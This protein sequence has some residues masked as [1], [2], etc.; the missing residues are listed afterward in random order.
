M[1]K[2]KSHWSL[3]K[4]SEIL[5]FFIAGDVMTGR[6]I[7]QLFAIQN[8]EDFGKHDSVPASQYQAWSTE[9]YGEV[10]KPV[11][12][13]YIWGSSLDVLK[14]AEPDFRLINLETAVTISRGWEN[15]KFNFRMHPANIGSLSVA[16]IDCCTLANN[17]TMD[18][19]VRGMLDTCESLENAGIGYA[20]AGANLA[21][22]CEPYIRVIDGGRRILVFSWGAG[23]S[24]VP[25]HWQALPDG[26]GLNYL[27][28]F[29][30]TTLSRMVD[31]IGSYRRP[32]DF[33]IASIHW[34]GNWVKSTP[35]PHRNL[36]RR[37]I[38]TAGVDIVHGHSSH[39]P[40]GVEVFKQKI[41]LY[42]CGDLINDYEGHPDYRSMRHH[43]GAM[44][45]VDFDKASGEVK[46]LKILPV[47]RR[48]F[49]LEKPSRNDS[50][51]LM[52][53]IRHHS[54]LSEGIWNRIL[55]S[56]KV[57]KKADIET[58]MKVQASR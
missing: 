44:Y 52:G 17:H 43:L 19:G 16:E 41:I 9:L 33:V 37:L 15:K 49:R 27:P 6:A 32:G 40:L 7:D 46:N 1:I 54:K 58:T 8:P 28:N 56:K 18:F 47:Q 4:P 13:E 14:L 51:W 3:S 29:T 36:A 35:E 20:G 22:A 5:R 30:S 10:F 24:G 21:K 2:S 38:E 48:R 55:R 39:H 11:R 12:H 23:D 34:G 45:F 25:A 50:D 42:G 31:L 57:N 53:L 26:P